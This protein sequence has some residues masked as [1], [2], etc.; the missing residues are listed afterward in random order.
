MKS[1]TLRCV[2]R[3]NGRDESLSM[4]RRRLLLV[5]GA[6]AL[7]VTGLALFLWLMGP[8]P[9]VTW[10]NF[11]RLREGMSV[12]D[13]QALLGQPYE[14]FEW[15][16][17]SCPKELLHQAKTDRCWRSEEVAICLVFDD[18]SRLTFG[19]AD[20]PKG[21]GPAEYLSSDENF[22]DLIRRWLGW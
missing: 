9:G 7:L 18:S 8:T 10:E 3:L 5:V 6:V 20:R 22:L 21:P 17:G 14:T 2:A 19:R 16:E 12:I 11:H 4:R 13:V 15:P 1:D